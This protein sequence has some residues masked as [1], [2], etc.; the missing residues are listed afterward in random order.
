MGEDIKLLNKIC[1]IISD[2]DDR[3]LVRKVM[4]S[5]LSSLCEVDGIYCCDIR[6]N[7]NQ[8]LI[9]F[10]VKSKRGAQ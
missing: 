4:M 7:D 10:V 1:D 8:R 5:I 2:Y 9:R 3:D 6:S